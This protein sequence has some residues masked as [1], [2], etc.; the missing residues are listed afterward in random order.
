MS[1]LDPALRFLSSAEQQRE[2][3][4]HFGELA[5]QSV[6]A[7][8]TEEVPEPTIATLIQ[9]EGEVEALEE[10]GVRLRSVVG[11]V[12][13]GEVALSAVEGLAALEQVVRVEA[14]R[15]LAPE[16]DL[17]VPD[18]GA[19][20]VHTG[21]P[22]L[23]GDGVIVGVIDSGIDWR[24]G[25]FRRA[26]GTSRVLAIWDQFLTPQG[27]ESSPPPFGYGVEY[28]QSRIDTALGS[29]NP[30]NVVRHQDV[31]AAN[32]HGTHVA[33]IA[34]GDGSPAGQGQ[35]A[36]TF[37][38]VAPEADLIV[39]ANNRGRASGERGLGDSAD[40]L[41][42]VRF[43]LD[44]AGSLGRPVVI[45]QSQG[46]NVGPHDGT[47][48][49]ERGIDNLLGGPGRAMVKSAGNEGSLNCHASGTVTA[50]GVVTASIAMP[51]NRA[52]PV[53]VDIWYRG[54]DR[55]R[56]SVVQPGGAASA[57][58]TPGTS[59][60]LTMANNNQVF[61]DSSLNDPGNGDNRIFVV[62]QRG[63]AATVQAGTWALSLQ[64]VTVTSGQW[65]AWIQRGDPRPQFLAPSVNPARTISIPGTSQKII[66][67]ASYITR[68][69]G[70]GNRSTF[71]SLGPT[72]DG[73]EA[74]T[75]AAPGQ[76]LMSAMP[77]STGDN[78]GLL[79][80]TSMAAPMI[81]GAVA[82]LLQRKPALTQSAIRTCLR[83]SARAD[84]F[85]ATV[86]NNAWG[87]GKLD[88]AAALDCVA[89]RRTLTVE[90]LR[91]TLE[92]RCVRAT[93][94]LTCRPTL[95][96]PCVR[97][98]L[99]PG[100]VIQTLQP[101]CGAHTIEAPCR[102]TLGPPCPSPTLNPTCPSPTLTAVCVQPT[103]ECPRHTLTCGP[104]G[105][106][107]PFG[108][109]RAHPP[110][111]ASP[112]ATSGGWGPAPGQPGPVGEGAWFAQSGGWGTD[113]GDPTTGGEGA[114]TGT[115][116][117]LAPVDDDDPAAY[118]YGNPGY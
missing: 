70:T 18:V 57:Q 3:E 17:A 2:E 13:V 12:A 28:P 63:T 16:L 37:V 47:S 108:P 102:H 54:P 46:D 98:T 77:A 39:V 9:F 27:S 56:L 116:G 32:F 81:A 100:C 29:A 40:T 74:P 60:T 115:P 21:P 87:A 73:R 14:S 20:A 49:L 69:A 79:S 41:D 67:A 83:S 76:A 101:P 86:P 103:L 92:V 52:A 58:V 19:D 64:G 96:D 31:A 36:S 48:L 99:D 51:A 90:C 66:T 10:A 91:P 114:D 44:R 97:V 61:V 88:A 82:L 106:V 109:V 118:W 71:S 6:F 105:P 111:E 55:I 85:T 35:P 89:P 93:M 4:A 94:D 7:L 59:T 53:T 30:L 38:G 42:A 78:Y 50:G 15:T 80:G 107:G 68:G 26:D 11:D 34:A 22:G 75:L 33:G 23:R 113:A 104:V 1:K 8:T 110:P 62:I 24:H 65:D 112:W 45:N 72:R 84:A 95:T 43:I 25:S 117:A 5:E